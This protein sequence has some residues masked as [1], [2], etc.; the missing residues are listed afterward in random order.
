MKTFAPQV[1]S[2]VKTGT[3]QRKCSC[4]DAS[5]CSCHEPEKEKGVI[6]RRARGAGSSSVSAPVAQG[7]QRAAGGGHGLPTGVRQQM[8]AGFGG[9]DFSQV[10]VHTDTNANQLADSL[11]A[12]A[13]TTGSNIFFAANQF[14]PNATEGRK[15]LAHELTHVVQ[16]G[17]THAS[18]IQPKLELGPVDTASEREADRVAE[19]VVSGAKAPPIVA[20]PK[21]T[22]QRVA[23]IPLARGGQAISLPSTE[24]LYLPAQKA[25]SKEDFDYLL[26][27]YKTA[28]KNK[29]LRT[30]HAGRKSG[31]WSTWEAARQGLPGQD[32]KAY[33]RKLHSKCS[34]DHM[35][36]LQVGG[37]D[38]GNNLRLLSQG[39]NEHA[40]SQIAGQL[41]SL[42]SKYRIDDNSW[43]EFTDVKQKSDTA[44]SPDE[45]CLTG[46]EPLKHPTGKVS[47]ASALHVLN[48]TAGGAQT[49]IGYES[50]GSIPTRHQYAIAG[51]QL[52]RVVAQNDGTHSIHAMISDRIRRFPLQG[53][54]KYFEFKTE[55]PQSAGQPTWPTLVLVNP[56]ALSLNFPGMSPATLTPRIENGQWRATG[57]LT[58]TLPILEKM[59]VWLEVSDEQLSGG[60][61]VDPALLKQALPVPG[62]VLDPV[63][64]EIAIQEGKFSATGG[65]DFRYGSL[66]HGNIEAKFSDAGFRAD[67]AISLAI[68]GIDKAE[69]KAWIQHGHFGAEIKIGAKQLKFP[70]VDKVIQKAE[71]AVLVAD[72]VLAGTGSI[73]LA[74]PGL[75][76]AVLVFK[77]D[78]TGQF[79]IEGTATGKIPGTKNVGVD[80][81]YIAGGLLSGKGHADL[82]IPGLENAAIN[83]VYINGLFSGS[84]DLAYKRGRLSGT[85]HAGLTPAHKLSGRGE[86]AYEVAPKLIVLVG[87]ELREDGTAKIDGGLK[88]PDPLIIWEGF[89]SKEKKLFSVHPPEIP[90]FAIPIGPKS[91]GVVAKFGAGLKA[92]IGVGP[93]EILKGQVLA[94]FDPSKDEGAFTFEASGI[95]HLPA[96]AGLTL[97]ME[98]KIG[99][100]L[101]VV[102]ADGGLHVDAM[103]QLVGELNAPID[104]KYEAG[105]FTIDAKP[106]VSVKIFPHFEF[107]GSA[108]VKVYTDLLVTDI[109]YYENTWPLFDFKWEPNFQIGMTFPLHYVFGEAFSF[110]SDKVHFDYPEFTF[111]KLMKDLLPF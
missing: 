72:G 39:R 33:E 16:Q 48:F 24:P 105:K 42:K 57:E 7:I 95:V 96:H 28:A 67:G 46:Q 91:V 56:G 9:R 80:I 27:L 59:K 71:L 86:L 49:R 74:I 70:G 102:E 8:E 15:M 75:D 73:H 92:D 30:T 47:V 109:T 5:K 40:G 99:L 89:P 2:A 100:D 93:L 60:L 37:Q 3:V 81:G 17:S 18:A 88:L 83:L 45:P 32:I 29:R 107:K 65:F 108:D 103:A 35:L 110:D 76:A 21:S 90:I 64:L 11:H 1:E 52:D 22:V 97:S 94:A 25:D 38:D 55:G 69:G 34:P 111:D 78:S 43:L 85:V 26:D 84:A 31:L 41:S 87:I 13:F 50:N 98:G 58:P 10:R 4:A 82:A 54:G 79:S 66:A 44:F 61:K 101:L 62:L 68:P 19:A 14:Q 6:Q 20:S 12:H 106:D 63:T 36:E 51:A 53:K 23:A 104:L 77:A